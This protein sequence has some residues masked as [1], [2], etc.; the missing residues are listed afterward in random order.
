[1][2]QTTASPFRTWVA[3]LSWTPTFECPWVPTERRAK[4]FFLLGKADLLGTGWVYIL[5][6]TIWQNL[7]PDKSILIIPPCWAPGL[8]IAPNEKQAVWTTYPVSEQREALSWLKRTNPSL[9]NSTRPEV[10]PV[11]SPIATGIALAP[12]RLHLP[13]T[14]T[15]QVQDREGPSTV[16]RA[17]LE[18]RRDQGGHYSWA[19]MWGQ[20]QRPTPDKETL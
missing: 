14:A 10:S 19:Q 11:S 4:C 3:I 7:G 16:S 5:A 20:N 18:G 1:M 17:L 12:L 13:K 2:F 9:L 6:N 8:K 15:E